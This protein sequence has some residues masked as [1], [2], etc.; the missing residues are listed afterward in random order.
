MTVFGDKGEL[1]LELLAI[2]LLDRDCARLVCGICDLASWDNYI[3]FAAIEQI[4]K[5]GSILDEHLAESLYVRM[6][7]DRSLASITSE[8]VDQLCWTHNA[9][10]MAEQFCTVMQVTRR[11][12]YT[13][14]R[15]T[16]VTI[17]KANLETLKQ[18]T[19]SGEAD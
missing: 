18:D 16:L 19:D 3:A 5:H 1:E 17:L 13:D 6:A 10:R 7:P 11:K 9:I 14:I 15:A 4:A 2:A 8:Q 12:G